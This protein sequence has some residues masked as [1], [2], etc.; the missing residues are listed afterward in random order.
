MSAANPLP[1]PRS[2]IE[3]KR[4]GRTLSSE[5]IDAFFAQ[6]A[7]GR[8]EPY[9][10][11]ALLMAVFLNGMRPAELEHWTRAMLHSG[12]VLSFA[13]LDKPVVDKHSTG[14]IGDKAS[15][16]LAPLLA[17]VGLAVPMISGRGLGHTGGTLDKLEAI[18]GFSTAVEPAAF[19][20][21][22]E[23][24]GVVFAGQTE[25]IAP[26]DRTLYALRD[27]TGLVESIPL[28]ASSILSK[29]LAEGLDALVLDV[30]FGSGAFL[31][32]HE[33][34]AELART[35]VTLA[36]GFGVRT[37]ALRTNM[38]RPLGLAIGHTLEVAESVACLR[39][40]GP[41]DLRE[42]VLALGAELV[43]ATDLEPDLERATARLATALDDGSALERFVRVVERQGGDPRLIEDPSRLPAAPSIHV[44]EATAAGHLRFDDLRA[45]GATVAALGGGRRKVTDRI[46]LCVGLEFTVAED[47]RVEVGQPLCLVHHA[48]TG[49]DEA[50]ALLSRAFHVADRPRNAPLVVRD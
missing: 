32:E 3:T 50:R 15:L 46:D 49:L 47:A 22:L 28:I 40:G 36:E 31:P 8:A 21:A 18:T 17:S 4:D 11:T 48:G 35:M 27:V 33:R 23:D 45:V 26:A 6:L 41:A 44:I 24:V 13:G 2:I 19:R 10:A 7:D 25:R 43:V 34:G 9:H 39:G 30:K 14:G 1:D 5:Q 37:S 29:K 42:L 16:P 20:P 12:D 38:D